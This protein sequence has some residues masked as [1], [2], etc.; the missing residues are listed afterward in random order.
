[1]TEFFEDSGAERKLAE[2]ATACWRAFVGFHGATNPDHSEGG[3]FPLPRSPLARDV[4]E[5]GIEMAGHVQRVAGLWPHTGS[6]PRFTPTRDFGRSSSTSP[7][8]TAR[9]L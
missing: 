4:A 9:R 5:T 3:T 6:R 1:V 8:K 7:Q 2:L